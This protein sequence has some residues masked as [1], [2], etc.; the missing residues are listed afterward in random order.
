MNEGWPELGVLCSAGKADHRVRL[1]LD[2]VP[3]AVSLANLADGRII[4]MNRKF[5]QLYGYVGTDFD[6]VQDWVARA[7]PVAEQQARAVKRWYGYF[8]AAS[9][10]RAAEFE[11]E[12][13]DVEIRCKD[14]KVKTAIHSGMILPD[15]GWAM[16]T[17]VDISDRKRD[18]LVIRQLAEED[19]LT[20]LPNRRAFEGHLEQ[21][22]AEAR[23]DGLPMHLLVLDLDHFKSVNDR[24]GHQGGDLLL[25]RIAE[26][27]RGCLR[28]SDVVARFGGDEFG[29][30]LG[31]SGGDTAVGRICD[32]VV[33]ELARPTTIEEQEVRTGVS[34][35]V[36]S[37]P[38]HGGDAARLF[39]AAD[40]ALYQVK[41]SGRGRW[42]L[43]VAEPDRAP[44][45]AA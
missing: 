8:T 44:G 1:V 10:A 26:R 32:K 16:A 31:R 33:A 2:A 22:L 11:I 20:R 38:V 5:T 40:R 42:Q 36:A 24:F 45:D 18:E 9:A 43:A 19:P 28:V 34:I 37:F 39:Q 12:P 21:S 17:F 15:P 14:G 35:G 4:F 27:L 3:V 25:Q 13:V 7:Y 23:R 29:I 30:I 6:T 41:R